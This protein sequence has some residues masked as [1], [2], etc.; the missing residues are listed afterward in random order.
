MNIHECMWTYVNVQE[1]IMKVHKNYEHSKTFIGIHENSFYEVVNAR[2]STAIRRFYEEIW[3]AT[4]VYDYVWM[5]LHIHEYMWLLITDY[6]WI[7][8]WKCIIKMYVHEHSFY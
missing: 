8:I 2:R 6:S 4:N 7:K 1:N 3:D 5:H